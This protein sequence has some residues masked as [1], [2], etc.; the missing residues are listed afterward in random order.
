L[1][2]VIRLEDDLIKLHRQDLS[3]WKFRGYRAEMEGNPIDPHNL[4]DHGPL[5]N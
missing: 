3:R 2:R 4:H 1:G 5:S